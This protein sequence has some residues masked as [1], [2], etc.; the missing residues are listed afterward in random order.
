VCGF[1]DAGDTHN[2][3]R[4]DRRRPES[5]QQSLHLKEMFIDSNLTTD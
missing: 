3:D 4:E 5:F 1:I 2:L